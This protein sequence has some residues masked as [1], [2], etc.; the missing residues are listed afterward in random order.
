[1]TVK[2]GETMNK[3]QMAIIGGLVIAVIVGVIAAN[4]L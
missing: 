2:E 3:T 1:M 4:G